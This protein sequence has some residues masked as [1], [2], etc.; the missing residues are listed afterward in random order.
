MNFL[1]PTDAA[2]LLD[3][4][5]FAWLWSFFTNMGRASWPDDNQRARYR[6]RCR[7]SL[8]GPLNYYRAS[9]LKPLVSPGWWPSDHH[10]L[11]LEEGRR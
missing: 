7:Q 6:A 4:N 3:E 8:E 5:D 11:A 2:A 9:P 10:V 1:F